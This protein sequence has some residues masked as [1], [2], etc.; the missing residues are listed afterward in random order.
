M[1]HQILSL[2]GC[3]EV[4]SQFFT[5]KMPMSDLTPVFNSLTTEADIRKWVEVYLN[6][7]L[8][9]FEKYVAEGG[10]V[11]KLDDEDGSNR[12][13]GIPL[14]VLAD[15]PRFLA[16]ERLAYALNYKAPEEYD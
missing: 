4:A 7:H 16:L 9:S 12:K 13:A 15:V 3:L 14:E 10:K 8:A 11:S 6:A 5:K 2:D 1:K